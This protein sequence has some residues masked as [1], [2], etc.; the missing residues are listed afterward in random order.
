MNTLLKAS[1]LGQRGV[2]YEWLFRDVNLKI[3][4][5]EI[6]IIYGNIGSGKTLLTD[7]LCGLK[8]PS[9]DLL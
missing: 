9:R 5:G 6:I 3:N 8:T 1:N 7:I 2:G 4:N